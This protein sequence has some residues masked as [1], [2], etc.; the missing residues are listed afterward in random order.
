LS[1]SAAG[2]V[3]GD[4]ID[5]LI[6]GARFGDP[7]GDTNAGETYV[8]FGKTTGF[9][10]SLD[11]SDLNGANGFVIN[12]I[13]ADDESGRSVSAAGD[14]N[15][16]GIDDLIIGARSADPGGVSGADETYVVFGKTTGFAASLELS[17]LDGV[18]GF[19]INGIDAGDYAGWSVSAAGDVN[20]DGIDDLIIGALGGDPGSDTNA[21]KTYVVFGKTT[22]FAA[23]L[24]LSALN[25]ANG[26]VIRGIDAYD[27]SGISVSA[28]GDVNGDGIDDL[29]IGA[30]GGDP[31]G[32]SLA[33]ESYMVFG[34]A[35]GFAASLELSAINGANGLVI[36]GIDAY[37]YS[38]FSVSAAG[39]VN[40]DGIDDLIIGA[41]GGD[42]G[43]DS[44]AGESYV[45]FGSTTLGAPTTIIGTPGPD[46]LVG[47]S[48]AELIDGLAGNDQ[49]LGGGGA[50]TLVAG[51]GDDTLNG[52]D[53]DDQ[54]FAGFGDDRLDGGAGDDF[55]KSGP[56]KDT[57]LGGDGNDTLAGGH[58]ADLLRGEGGNDFMLGSNG[59]DRLFGG[60]GDDTLLGGNG[61]DTLNGGAGADRLN[62]GNQIDWASYESAG[63]GV[64]VTLVAGGGFAGDALFDVLIDIENL[65]GSAFADTLTGDAGANRLD[66]GAG[67]DALSG[68]GG[69]DIL[70]GEAGADTLSGGAGDDK[71]WYS[72]GDDADRITDFTAGAG[73]D[74]AIRLFGFGAAFDTF[75]EVIAASSQVGADTMI[76]FG[77]GNSITLTGVA[78]GSLHADDFLFG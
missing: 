45:I 18:N 62:G 44:S 23:V 59:N 2:D 74:D 20:G 53:G 5:D 67:A 34:K 63:A 71:F 7:G 28:A 10:A 54:L 78:V 29:I 36:N 61:R 48:A 11:L 12:G 69:A 46:R 76:D 25:G 65:L 66:G 31:G 27:V 13:D 68:A 38:G 8:V 39:D 64:L 37:D 51:A 24:E 42:P 56:G 57:L 41:R 52:G 77:G 15:G 9:A 32:V 17:A 6:I 1:V 47:T 22:G 35:T 49:L 14:V 21:G 70:V 43:G 60:D 40:G 3:N 75:A 19:V 4:G 26:F 16:D 58:K 73:S 72:S 50:D 30:D 55:M 33:G